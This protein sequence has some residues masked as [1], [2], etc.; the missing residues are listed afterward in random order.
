MILN[1]EGQAEGI[2]TDDVLQGILEQT[3]RNL[4]QQTQTP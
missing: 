3:P 2:A 1:F 4:E